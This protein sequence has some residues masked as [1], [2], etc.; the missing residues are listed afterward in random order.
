M[1]RLPATLGEALRLIG[2]RIGPEARLNCREIQYDYTASF[3]S[4]ISRL[5]EAKRGADQPERTS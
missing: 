2:S 3:Q 5:R 1:L 4:A